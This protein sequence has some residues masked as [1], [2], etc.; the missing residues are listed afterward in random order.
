M[1][2]NWTLEIE[3][4]I[5]ELEAQRL[6]F[7]SVTLKEDIKALSKVILE[8]ESKVT[9]I[10]VLILSTIWRNSVVK[11]QFKNPLPNLKRKT[12]KRLSING[13]V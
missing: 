10:E 9:E 6:I 8:V 12:E 13:N 1:G 5:F 11:F 7:L 4:I 3:K 2:Q